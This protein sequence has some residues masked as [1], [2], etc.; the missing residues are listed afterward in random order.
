[1]SAA[2]PLAPLLVPFAIVL[3]A[4]KE[5]HSDA[6]RALRK[7]APKATGQLVDALCGD[8]SDFDVRRRIPSVLSV[9]T[10]QD[11][12]NGLVRGTDDERFEVR[13][14]CARALLKITERDPRIVIAADTVMA[15]VKREVAVSKEAWASQPGPQLDEEEEDEAPALVDRLVRDRI[16]RG[17][18]HVFTLLAL[19]LDRQSLRL[20]FKALH[21]S[22]ERLRGTA[23]EYLETV[24]PDDIRDAVWPF[25]GEERPMRSPRS[26][27]EIL[28][29][30]QSAG[31]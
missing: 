13:Y 26:P 22:D 6:I 8:A 7:C 16:D 27:L 31:A 28:A 4:D 24:L 20:A 11:A 17:V 30:L 19:R 9:C 15:M 25:L 10:T 23:L 29:D 21:E 3:L 2:V 1:L 14:A 12:A 5:L 18:E